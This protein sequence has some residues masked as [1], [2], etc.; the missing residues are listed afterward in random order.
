[1]GVGDSLEA[2]IVLESDVP[3]GSWHLVGDGIVFAPV[4]VKYEVIRR[5]PPK[6]DQLLVTFNHH[7]DPQMDGSFNAVPFEGSAEGVMASVQSGDLLV[8]RL[9]AT[10]GGAM[11]TFVPNGDGAKTK[12][13]IPSLEIPH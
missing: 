2:A 8:L 5:H 12:G 4:D 7:F 6:S 11:A 3:A 9:T 10:G 13:R 1:M